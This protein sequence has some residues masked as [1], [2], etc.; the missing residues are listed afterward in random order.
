MLLSKNLRFRPGC[1]QKSSVR[2]SGLGGVGQNLI[3]IFDLEVVMLVVVVLTVVVAVVHCAPHRRVYRLCCCGCHCRCVVLVDDGDKDVVVAVIVVVDCSLLICLFVLFVFHVQEI[4][5]IILGI[6]EILA[7][8]SCFVTTPCSSPGLRG[9][10]VADLEG[11][12]S[13]LHSKAT[14]GTKNSCGS[15]NIA[16]EIRS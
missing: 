7:V 4:P 10:W 6:L 14:V 9:R 1:R 8:K 16:T 12:S 2:N 11:V 13:Q 15:E 5:G 3:L